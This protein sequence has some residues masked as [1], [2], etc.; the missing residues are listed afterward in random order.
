MMRNK[1]DLNWYINDNVVEVAQQLLGKTLCTRF[2]G[3][4]TKGKIVE[5]EAYSGDNDKACHANNQRMTRRNRVMFASGGRAYV[6]LCYGIHHLF[7]VVTNIDGKADA[8]LIRAIEPIEGIDTML[9]RRNMDIVE[10]RLSAGP[11]VLSQALGITTDNYGEKLDGNKIWIEKNENIPTAEIIAAT[12][13]GVAYA[14]EDALKP[15]RFYVKENKWV[16]RF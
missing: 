3:I 11:G 14:E 8:V 4:T 9:D 10:K 15:W 13:I 6:Y 7:N 5:T 2:D 16:S 1:V 12:R